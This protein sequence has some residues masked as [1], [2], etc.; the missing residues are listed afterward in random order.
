[1]HYQEFFVSDL[2]ALEFPSSRE[3]PKRKKDLPSVRR[4]SSTHFFL[5]KKRSDSP[6]HSHCHSSVLPLKVKLAHSL[7]QDGTQVVILKFPSTKKTSQNQPAA[8]FFSSKNVSFSTMI[9]CQKKSS[10]IRHSTPLKPQSCRLNCL[11]S[12]SW[13]PSTCFQTQLSGRQDTSKDPWLL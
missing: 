1:M 9:F 13:E 4:W 2:E 8:W 3:L 6:K 7:L 10:S 12:R 5:K 11:K